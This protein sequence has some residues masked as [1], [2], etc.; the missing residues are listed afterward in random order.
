MLGVDWV[1][2]LDM[3]FLRIESEGAAIF[4]SF[5]ELGLLSDE[6]A[7]VDAH[8]TATRLQ[9]LI[10][11]LNGYFKNFSRTRLVKPID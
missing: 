5:V 11:M 1:S 7:D 3:L 9:E 4:L 10:C 8:E 2:V 6:R